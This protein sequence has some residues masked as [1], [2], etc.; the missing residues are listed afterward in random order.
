M[1]EHT[2]PALVSSAAARNGFARGLFGCLFILVF[3]LCAQPA[4][5]QTQTVVQKYGQ[6]RVSG[7]KIV[8]KSGTPVQLRGMSLY[9][10]QWIPKYWSYN[11]VKWLRDDWKITVIRAAMAVDSGGYSTNPTVEKNKVFTVVDAAI[12]LGIYV[13]IDY[14]A[15]EAYKNRAQAQAFFAEMAQRYGGKPNVIYETFNEPLDVSWSATLK[16]YHT[17]V[18]D[19][20]RKYDP[21]NIVVCG[22]RNWSQRVDEAAADP[23]ARS[24]VAYTL[25]FYADSHR[26]WLRDVAQGALNKGIA[27]FVTE[28]GTT[29]ASGDGVVNTTESRAWWNFL[30][31]NKISHANWSVADIG[32]SSAALYP[33]ASPNG[34]WAVSQIKPSGQ[35]VRNELR[36]KAPDLTTTT[37]TPPPPPTATTVAAGTYSL[38]NRA[39]GKMLDNMGSTA[40]GTGVKQWSDGSSYNQRWVLS[41]VGGYAKLMCPTGNKYLDSLGHTGTNTTVGQW[42]NSTSYNQQ[43]SIVSVGGGY[44]KI[45]NRA[46]GLC[47]DTG[48]ATGNG[49]ADMEFWGSGGTY[50]QQWQFVAP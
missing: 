39:S 31:Q 17:A 11:T 28:Y 8:D 6:L 15:H 37:T 25:H 30:D 2:H 19:T 42:D 50:N 23:I 44:Y 34:N 24:N 46:N 38:R 26:Q 16:P 14:H 18:I 36:A 49:D 22:T 35:L 13:V 4:A 7:N 20:I 41:Y 29:G 47:L 43:W 21:D 32:E 40:N 9:W 1:K 5:A 48:G 45:I 12:S 3:G 27:L 10:S 33:N